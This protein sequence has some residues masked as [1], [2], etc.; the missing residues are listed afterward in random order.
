[1]ATTRKLMKNIFE[2]CPSL[3]EATGVRKPELSL[4]TRS[5]IRLRQARGE[6][7]VLPEMG[8]LKF[9]TELGVLLHTN[10]ARKSMAYWSALKQRKTKLYGLSRCEEW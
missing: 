1:M 8:C 2:P 4:V 6:R 7:L 9:L 5:S 10:P 3:G